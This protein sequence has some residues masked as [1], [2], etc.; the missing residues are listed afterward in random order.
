MRPLADLVIAAVSARPSATA[1]RIR[2]Q[3]VRSASSEMLSK[4]FPTIDQP[5]TGGANRIGSADEETDPSAGESD[6]R[7]TEPGEDIPDEETSA[8]PCPRRHRNGCDSTAER[9]AQIEREGLLDKASLFPGPCRSVVRTANSFPP[10]SV[11]GRC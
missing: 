2:A 8:E 3:V 7:G 11:P 5:S 9:R 10:T 1:R 4:T 6:V